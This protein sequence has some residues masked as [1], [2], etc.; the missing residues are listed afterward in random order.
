T[1]WSDAELRADGHG[2]SP[3]WTGPARCRTST[4]RGSPDRSFTQSRQCEVGHDQEC[5]DAA[6]FT[7]GSFGSIETRFRTHTIATSTH[8]R[9]EW[10]KCALWSM[11][12]PAASSGKRGRTPRVSTRLTPAP[13]FAPR[14]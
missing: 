6:I 2:V 13:A 12:D 8:V 4:E 1:H 3:V 5:T 7:F 9:E 11:T 10:S 14:P